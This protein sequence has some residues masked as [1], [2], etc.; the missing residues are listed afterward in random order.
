[1]AARPARVRAPSAAALLAVADA[2]EGGAP[3]AE[4]EVPADGEV[5]AAPA[6]KKKT[7]QKK[8]KAPKKKADVV[9]PPAAPDPDAA[10]SSDEEAD[11]PKVKRTKTESTPRVA[12][13]QCPHCLNPSPP[14][15]CQFDDCGLRSD[16]AWD[17]SQ[18]EHIRAKIE[19]ASAGSTSG[20]PHTETR[21]SK[22]DA[23]LDRLSR[24]LPAYPLFEQPTM[25]TVDQA[26]NAIAGAY[27]ACE[28]E[29]TSAATIAYIQS[30]RMRFVGDAVPVLIDVMEIEART[31][32][33]TLASIAGI[34]LAVSQPFKHRV[35]TSLNEYYAA[36]FGTILPSLIENTSALMQ[37][38]ALTR[39]LQELAA[40]FSWD[41][42][43]QYLN[44]HLPRAITMRG[45]FGK[46]DADI[47]LALA[48][49]R[50]LALVTKVRP[51]APAAAAA[52]TPAAPR[53]I[54]Q[55]VAPSPPGGART[56][57]A[58]AATR[59]ATPKKACINYNF[60]DECRTVGCGFAHDCTYK[61]SG[62][63]T[64]PGKHKALNC[65][66]HGTLG[67]TVFQGRARQSTGAGSQRQ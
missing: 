2:P 41:V 51:A 57:Q 19:R 7:Q 26:F 35:L 12:R 27:R 5:V 62:A 42:A 14:G 55:Q 22:R 15:F 47:V 33:A 10:A 46:H 59:A 23:E 50:T 66:H 38:V 48:S 43:L 16:Q 56:K 3:A 1:M 44:R 39:T 25:C 18:N 40:T 6:V 4:I 63:C 60:N 30:G 37:W 29:T 67:S 28:S 8:R 53:T 32:G 36:L 31:G 13:N 52:A 20:T 9:A 65:E 24:T 17:S 49:A 54:T 21:L 61:D 45:E 34:E 58:P 11:A 64:T